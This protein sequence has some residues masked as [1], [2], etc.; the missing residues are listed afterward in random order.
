MDTPRRRNNVSPLV[1]TCL[2]VVVLSLV[3]VTWVF[4]SDP[5]APVEEGEPA[6]S[7]TSTLHSGAST[8]HSRPP[9]VHESSAPP[10]SGESAGNAPAQRSAIVMGVVSDSVAPHETVQLGGHLPRPVAGVTLRTQQLQ[11]EEWISFPLP[12][13]TDKAGTFTAFVELARMGP[14]Q[15]RVV[16]TDTQQPSNVVTVYVE[17]RDEASSR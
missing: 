12:V 5:T 14:T 11:G 3:F 6:A 15:L 10:S 17:R 8:A 4:L 16:R 2:V 13:V 9:T 7:Q 1:V